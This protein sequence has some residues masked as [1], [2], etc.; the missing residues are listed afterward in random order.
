MNG[1]IYFPT[2][3]P[4]TVTAPFSTSSF[5]AADVLD[6]SDGANSNLEFSVISPCE[7]NKPFIMIDSAGNIII[8]HMNLA[9]CAKKIDVLMIVM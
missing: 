3:T 8:A 9:V 1:D 2:I 5:D 6:A 4:G 7:K